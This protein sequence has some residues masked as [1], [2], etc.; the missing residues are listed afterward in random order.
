MVEALGE[1]PSRDPRELTEE[2]TAVR[3]HVAKTVVEWAHCD[4]AGIV[5]YPYFYTWF[6][7]GT[8]RLFRANRLSYAELRRDF[9][10]AGMPLLETGARYTNACKLGDELVMR[11]WVDEW[12]GRTFL[13][14]HA[15]VHADGRPA[16]EGFERR[17]WAVPDPAAPPAP[18]AGTDSAAAGANAPTILVGPVK[19]SSPVGVDFLGRP[20][21]EPTILKIAAAYEQATKLRR[22]PADFGPLP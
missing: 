8:E 14:K 12:A 13:V 10:V 20:F 21:A 5:F 19:V 7:Q 2:N 15:I 6:D 4:A 1:S 22:P 17:V 18:P 11:T 16:L 9:G 3:E